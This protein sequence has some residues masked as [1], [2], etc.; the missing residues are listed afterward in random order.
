M[1]PVTTE[2]R[3][4]T[5]KSSHEL[6]W[7]S[8]TRFRPG[9]DVA[10]IDLSTGGALI[11]GKVRFL[12]SAHVV[13]Q[14]FGQTGCHFAC[15]SVLRCQVSAITPEAGVTYRGALVFDH[16]MDFSKEARVLSRYPVPVNS[17]EVTKPEGH[18]LPNGDLIT[19]SAATNR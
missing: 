10:L 8:A 12:P 6:P 16:V 19:G 13:L 7:L 4:T 2:R 18:E 9:R 11:E 17:T 14:L 3:V 1:D 5:R 15:G